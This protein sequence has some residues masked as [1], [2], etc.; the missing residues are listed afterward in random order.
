MIRRLIFGAALLAIAAPG[1]A[2]TP[3]VDAARAAGQEA[4]R[5]DAFR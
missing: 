1:A 5:T 3:Q 4:H 2:Q